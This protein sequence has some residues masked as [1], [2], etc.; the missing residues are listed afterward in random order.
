MK[1]A[2]EFTSDWTKDADVPSVDETKASR[3]IGK[4][5]LIGVTYET[6]KGEVTGRQQWAGIIKTYSNEE[7][8]QVDL[9]DSEDFCALPPWPDAISPARPGVY[10]LK[11]TGREIVDP[12]YLATWT[13]SEPDPRETIDSEQAVDGTPH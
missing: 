5:V 1:N 12:D 13:C 6:N 9:F 2:P 10:R 3:Y 7:G 8:I 4:V 11:S